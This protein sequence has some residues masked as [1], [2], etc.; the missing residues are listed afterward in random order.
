MTIAVGLRLR[1]GVVLCADTLLSANYRTQGRK[2]WFGKAGVVELAVSGAG[3]Y[4]LVKRAASEML[5]RLKKGMSVETVRQEVVRHVLK[6]M[7]EGDI[8][9]APEW[10]Q[11]QGYCLQVLIGIKCHGDVQL[12]E[13][14]R[15]SIAPVENVACV[16][17]GAPIANYI[18]S[19]FHS[20][21]F[22]VDWGQILAAY[23]IQQAKTYGEDCGGDTNIVVMK[24]DES[25]RDLSPEKVRELERIGTRLHEACGPLLR[26]CADSA[27]A[28]E[29]AAG[30][31]QLGQAIA[32]SR[33]AVIGESVD[34][35]MRSGPFERA[36]SRALDPPTPQRSRRGRKPRPPSQE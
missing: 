30:L 7:Y 26:G 4:V 9:Q 1:D 6:N 35:F 23:L 27:D 20:P 29:I 8:D 15:A 22:S 17:S 3:D 25:S 24:Q 21:A 16:G 10:R 19:V 18:A 12:Y 36:L 34:T 33:R 13:S 31:K 5:R 2:V 32:D 11:Q 28:P 14:S